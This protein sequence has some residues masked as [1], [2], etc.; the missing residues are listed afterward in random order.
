MLK[1]K[2]SAKYKA[3]HLELLGKRFDDEM[4]AWNPHAAN[5][6]PLTNKLHRF[7][8]SQREQ[9][10][11][12][13]VSQLREVVR[14]IN[15]I[16]P[17]L[18][19]YLQ[20]RPKKKSPL[21]RDDMES[22]I[23]VF[24]D[25]FDY[26]KFIYKSVGWNAYKLVESHG[27]RICP[28]C[29]LHHVNYHGQ[30]TKKLKTLE[31]RPPLDH[32]LP[33]SI[34]P[35]LAVSLHNLVPCCHQCNS[36]IKGDNDPALRVPHPFDLQEILDMSFSVKSSALALSGVTDEELKLEVTGNGAWSEFVSFF[37]LQPR[38]QWYADEVKDML[39]RG[40]E[41]KEFDGVVQSLVRRP[42]FILGFE[43]DDVQRRALGLCLREI[44]SQQGLV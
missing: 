41:F 26:G 3:C 17:D 37:H 36:S 13:A 1:L 10:L 4:G 11:I 7:L 21:Y 39:K 42:A 30:T 12:G 34:Y 43:P 18:P 32:F 40:R 35:Y 33:K 25:V 5:F 9:I 29:H 28:Y 6:P 8:L 15:N 16:M 31:M 22:L 24:G 27:L 19:P 2:V 44:A 14:Q 23:K 38:Y 20:S